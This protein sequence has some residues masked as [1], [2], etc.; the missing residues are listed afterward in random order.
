MP[1]QTIA[2]R[3]PAPSHTAEAIAWTCSGFW[4][5]FASWH[6]HKLV[7]LLA[8]SHSSSFI[9]TCCSAQRAATAKPRFRPTPIHN[10]AWPPSSSLLQFRGVLSSSTLSRSASSSAPRPSRPFSTSFRSQLPPSPSA[11]S[12]TSSSSH[13]SATGPTIFQARQEAARNAYYKQRN[14]SLLLYTA[15]V[16]VLGVGVTYAAVPL[17]VCHGQHAAKTAS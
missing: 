3:D 17:Y 2:D 1:G 6:R 15:A 10:L 16:L 5:Y 14:K 8:M 7:I 11:R 4:R 9:R 13:P 12:A